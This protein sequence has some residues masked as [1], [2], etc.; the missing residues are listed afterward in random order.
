MRHGAWA[1]VDQ[2]HHGIFFCR[3][4]TAGI[5]QPALKI[6]SLI[7]PVNALL[8]APGGL[9]VAIVRGDLL[10]LPDRAG[11]NFRRMR[12]GLADYGSGFAIGGERNGGAPA[13]RGDLLRRMQEGFHLSTGEIYGADSAFAVHFLAEEDFCAPG[14]PGK[15][16]G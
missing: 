5:E 7:L 8:V 9:K 3:I 16:T 10:P 2:H 4:K 15:P 1:A 12:E 11:P 13:V 14:C 6:E